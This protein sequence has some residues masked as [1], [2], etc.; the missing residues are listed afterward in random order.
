LAIRDAMSDRIEQHLEENEVLRTERRE[1]EYD[2][3]HDELTGL[4]NRRAL[5][6][7]LPRLLEETARTATETALIFTDLDGF[8]EIND[9]FGH[10]AGD[11]VLRQTADRLRASV[12]AS[13]EV[14]RLGG[15]EFLT[16]VGCSKD[17]ARRRAADVAAE[18]VRR[19][20][21]PIIH[22]GGPPLRVTASVGVSLAPS[23][24]LDPGRLLRAADRAMYRV[25]TSGKSGFAFYQASE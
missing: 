14:F 12:G 9:R 18:I 24:G 1:R 8:K 17:G 5:D 6:A 3:N 4:M 23:D 25:K 15:D 10:A 22:E 2:A 13:D 11:E 20:G 19:T 21:Q 16:V 7:M